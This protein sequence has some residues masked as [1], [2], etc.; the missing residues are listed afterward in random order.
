L[1]FYWDS[2]PKRQGYTTSGLQSIAEHIQ[3]ERHIAA[4]GYVSAY[5]GTCF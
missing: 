4:A 2:K 5:S 1:L 3:P